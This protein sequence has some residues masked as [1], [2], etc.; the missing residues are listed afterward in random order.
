MRDM[1]SYLGL[2]R[3]DLAPGHTLTLLS[4]KVPPCLLIPARNPEG[5]IEALH[6]KPHASSTREN[7]KNAV[8]SSTMMCT[9]I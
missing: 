7:Q 9:I 6:Y 3:S 8:L 5:L 2:S 4:R 1:P